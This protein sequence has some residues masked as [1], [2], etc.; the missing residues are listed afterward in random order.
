MKAL[1]LITLAAGL[2]IGCAKI[3]PSETL[4][5]NEDRWAKA[6]FVGS[7]KTRPTW[8]SR[9]TVVKTSMNDGFL[10]TGMQS[11]TKIGYFAFSPKKLKFY[12]AYT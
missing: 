3:R 7:D 9:V 8:L 6:S 4:P 5:P 12:N 2:I 10:F 1:L 11:D